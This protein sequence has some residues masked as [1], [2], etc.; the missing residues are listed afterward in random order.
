[1]DATLL[2]E[3][4]NNEEMDIWN[5]YNL[6]TDDTMMTSAKDSIKTETTGKHI[7]FLLRINST[8]FDLWFI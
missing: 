2:L 5:N 7:W 8:W 3:T 1:M 6:F 4:F